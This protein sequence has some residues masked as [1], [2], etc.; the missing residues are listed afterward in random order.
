MAISTRHALLN[1]DFG[2]RN[3]GCVNGCTFEQIADQFTLS[4]A[5]D[6][7]SFA[8]HLRARAKQCPS[9]TESSTGWL[10]CP[11]SNARSSAASTSGMKFLFCPFHLLWRASKVRH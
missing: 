5:L 9:R 6:W 11:Q 4:I 1:I 10:E 8:Q 7:K 2:Q 3:Y